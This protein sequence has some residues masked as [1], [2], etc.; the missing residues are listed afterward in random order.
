MGEVTQISMGEGIVFFQSGLLFQALAECDLCPELAPRW[1][2]NRKVDRCWQNMIFMCLQGEWTFVC[3]CCSFCPLLL[4]FSVSGTL[5]KQAKVPAFH[6]KHQL[7][8]F[9]S[10]NYNLY[11]RLSNFSRTCL[12]LIFK[13]GQ[14]V[15]LFSMSLWYHTLDFIHTS[16]SDVLCYAKGRLEGADTIKQPSACH[17]FSL[18]SFQGV[19][20]VAKLKP[21]THNS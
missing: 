12:L 8:F 15:S 6:W 11:L 5:E 1:K 17:R 7:F 13:A 18:A 4:L 2:S 10:S 16:M 19:R 3:P 14:P 20:F 21:V 9:K